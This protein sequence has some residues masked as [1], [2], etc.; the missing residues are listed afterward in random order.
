[1]KTG[2]HREAE[3]VDFGSHRQGFYLPRPAGP[4]WRW[5][6][7]EYWHLRSDYGQLWNL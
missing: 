7:H 1:M 2:H 6:P 4:S 3:T 5:N